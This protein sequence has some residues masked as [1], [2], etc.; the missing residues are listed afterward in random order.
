MSGPRVVV[1]GAGFAGAA[2]AL[3]LARAGARVV[4]LEREAMA[5]IHATSQNAGMLRTAIADPALARVAVAGAR[6]VELAR[7]WTDVPLVRPSGSLLLARGGPA[8][9]ELEAVTP[10]LSALRSTVRWLEPREAAARVPVLRDG[11]FDAALW[12]PDDGVVDSAEYF[13]ALVRG[14]RAHGAQLRLGVEVLGGDPGD[15]SRPARLDTPAGPLEADAVV[16]AGGAW[17]DVVAERLQVRRLGIVPY[18]RH[19]HA[20]GPLATVD[21][22]WPF[23]WAVDDEVYFRPESGG[24]LLSPCD[25]EPFAPCEPP[26]DPANREL[27]A[28]KVAVAFPGLIDLPIMRSWAGLRSFVPDHRFVLGRDPV[29]RRVFWAA[30]L[31]GHGVTSA[32]EVGRIVAGAVLGTAPPPPEFAPGR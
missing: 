17:S 23:V 7:A 32:W 1:V 18:R 20:T 11:A 9:R 16:I 2:T 31:G 24:L 13:A 15:D 6:G 27:L 30:G 22:S 26:A 8:R 19:L 12:S 21:P 25:Q 3:H 5:G 14:A 29:A 4:V 28:R 10:E